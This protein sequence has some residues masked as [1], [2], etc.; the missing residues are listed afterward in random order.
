MGGLP[1]PRVGAVADPLIMATDLVGWLMWL[2]WE[3][4][5]MVTTSKSLAC[6]MTVGPSYGVWGSCGVCA[7]VR[8][9]LSAKP[10]RRNRK[11]WYA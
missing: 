4:W 2:F 1:G 7:T 9:V 6:W 11:G 3:R 10:T 5:E 8:L